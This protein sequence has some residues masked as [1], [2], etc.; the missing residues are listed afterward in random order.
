MS[1]LQVLQPGVLSL[2][3]DRGRYGWHH[4]GL[5]NGGPVDG[6]AMQLA[7]R[8]LGN[9]PA[10]TCIEISIGG[11]ELEAR[12]DTCIACTGGDAPMHLNGRA[13]AHWRGHT[14]R[15]GDRLAIGYARRF[16]RSYLAVAGGFQVEPQF[17]STATVV[18]EGIGGAGGKPLAR[19]DLLPCAASPGHQL[20][21]LAAGDIPQYRDTVSLRV[22][23]GYQLRHF[24]RQQ[25][26]RLFTSEYTVTER[27][28]RMGYR[29]RGPVIGCDI[30][31]IL[32]EGIGHGA[33]QIPA[34][35]QPIVL[36]NDRQTI[37]GYPKIGS[38][39][40]LDTSRLG[41]LSR[42]GRVRFEPIS[43]VA[44][45]EVLRLQYQQL[46]RLGLQPVREA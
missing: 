23:P 30:D 44:A 6:L 43:A 4:I 10:A 42:G 45:G 13:A 33:I 25:R 7:N 14:L 15:A 27:C 20:L 8:L 12:L 5:T 2:L 11:L 21:Q 46:K 31:G 34:D 3:Q 24:P 32:S 36:M 18:R 28:D 38:V 19:G 39:L 17:G 41:Q 16:C 40:S 35:G 29:L 1:G 37:G 26:R 22:I 9:D